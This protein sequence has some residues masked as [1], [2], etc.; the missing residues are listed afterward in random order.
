MLETPFDLSRPFQIIETPMSNPIL[1]VDLYAQYL[2]IK[3][4]IDF[5]ISD[6]IQKSS[7]VRGPYVEKFEQD[8][9]EMMDRKYCV[10]CANGTDSLHRHE[11]FRCWAC[12]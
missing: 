9:A 6:V 11:S 2:T 8:F 12:R 10:S 7:F 5:V 3:D 4:E 1:F